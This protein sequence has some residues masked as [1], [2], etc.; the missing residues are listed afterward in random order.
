VTIYSPAYGL[1]TND[2]D[3][4]F[5]T[6]RSNQ[7]R[8]FIPGDRN[9]P[10]S[11][12]THEIG[13]IMTLDNSK[14]PDSIMGSKEG[15]VTALDIH[16]ILALNR[17]FPHQLPYPNPFGGAIGGFPSSFYLGPGNYFE[18]GASGLWF[19]EVA[20]GFI[21]IKEADGVWHRAN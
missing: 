1:E 7:E 11:V 19:D 4:E 16:G 5:G 20:D 12:L 3:L 10:A 2:I 14:N 18:P 17:G 15:P 8:V 21:F 6:D 9:D 13:H